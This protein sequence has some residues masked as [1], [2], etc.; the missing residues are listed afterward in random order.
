M[1]DQIRGGVEGNSIG[2]HFMLKRSL[3]RR[4]E[5]ILFTRNWKDF[6]A[7]LFRFADDYDFSAV[8]GLVITDHSPTLTEFITIA[9]LP[10]GFLPSFTN[11]DEGKID[12]VMQF[13]KKSHEP[14]IWNEKT[15]SSC[16]LSYLWEKQASFGLKSGIAL[17]THMPRGRHFLI[18]LDGDRKLNNAHKATA[19]TVADLKVFIAYAEAAAYEISTG[20]I[21]PADQ[22]ISRRDL[23]LLQMSMSGLTIPAI[24]DKLHLSPQTIHLRFRK[25][26]DALGCS[27]RYQAVLRTIRLG[28]L[29]P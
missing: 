26:L 8:S 12:P 5:D 28:L 13:C 6:S 20:L 24:A 7:E 3:Q 4:C 1:F 11:K 21:S 22:Q 9:R 15:Y 2:V 19:N 14:I 16:D 25:I 23:E 29:T 10:T 18:G 27:T 17:A